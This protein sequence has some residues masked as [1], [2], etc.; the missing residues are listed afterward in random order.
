M[1]KFSMRYFDSIACGLSCVLVAGAGFAQAPAATG[2]PVAVQ[3]AAPAFREIDDPHSGVRWLVVK[4]MEHPGGPGRL[5]PLAA[6][7]HPDVPLDLPFH[8]PKL[9][10]AA[11]VIRAGD[12]IV[13]EE[14]TDVVDAVLEA[15]ALGPA[16]EQGPLNARLRIGGRVV[17]V[18]A[19]APGRARLFS[20]GEAR[21]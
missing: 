4:D 10:A 16:V 17:R 13:V 11:P 8:A 14:H 9:A 15:V 21:P 20:K 1:V 7:R 18:V 3:A 12:R 2:R 6:G 5:V 19:L